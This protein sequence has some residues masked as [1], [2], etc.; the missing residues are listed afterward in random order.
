MARID[1]LIEAY[2]PF[3]GSVVDLGVFEASGAFDPTEA[4]DELYGFGP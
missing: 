4:F 1:D 2:D 3:A